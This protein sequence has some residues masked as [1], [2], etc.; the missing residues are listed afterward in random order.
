MNSS[1]RLAILGS[2][3]IALLLPSA[4]ASRDPVPPVA[5]VKPDARKV[6]RP[7][8]AEV[9]G[10]VGSEK[11]EP[12]VSPAATGPALRRE[13]FMPRILEALKKEPF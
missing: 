13:S 4:V 5:P 2:V 1:R 11:A 6:L 12:A 8:E 9:K 7:D 10:K 3:A